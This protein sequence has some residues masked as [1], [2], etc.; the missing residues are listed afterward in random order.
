VVAAKPLIEFADFEKIDLRV[1]T[2]TAAAAVPKA[3]KLLQLTVSL[4]PLDASGSRTIVSGIAQHYTPE[5][6]VGQRVLVVANLAPRKMR[7]VESQGMILLAESP[8][9]DGSGQLTLVQPPAG[10]EGLPDGS[11]VR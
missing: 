8:A 11:V 6:L 3:D 1:G 10:T 9:S 4:G 2:V 5:Q 7:G